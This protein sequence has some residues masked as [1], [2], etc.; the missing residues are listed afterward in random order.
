MAVSESYTAV[1]EKA[2]N[3][4]GPFATEPYETGWAHE[5]LIFL[6]TTRAAVGAGVAGRIQVSPDGIDWIDE[7]SSLPPLAGEG[8]TFAKV[9]HFGSWLRVVGEVSGPAPGVDLM[10]YIALKE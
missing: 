7:G 9:A 4:T 2:Q 10:V 5:A 3:V 8:M 1:V 6:K